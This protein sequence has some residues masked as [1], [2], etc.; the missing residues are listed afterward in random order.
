[1]RRPSHVAIRAGLYVAAT[2]S[3]VAAAYVVTE[4]ILNLRDSWNPGLSLPQSHDDGDSDGEANHDMKAEPDTLDL[5]AGYDT[6]SSPTSFGHA[7]VELRS[8][9][10]TVDL[11]TPV[12]DHP[13]PAHDED[14]RPSLSAGASAATSPTS[15]LPQLRIPSP[16]LESSLA[17]WPALSTKNMSP[18]DSISPTSSEA[19][20][21]PPLSSPRTWPVF[22]SEDSNASDDDDP[23]LK[24]SA[25]QEAEIASFATILSPSMRTISPRRVRAHDLFSASHLSFAELGSLMA[26]ERHG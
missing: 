3:G 18:S 15:T 20:F 5:S 11:P 23:Q 19:K 13:L 10:Y 22:G 26:G 24:N 21:S 17:D 2:I 14:T 16:S 12:S 4:L 6:G 8:S 9:D 7:S 25:N 1:M